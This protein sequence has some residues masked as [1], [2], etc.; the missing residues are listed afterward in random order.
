MARP[1]KAAWPCALVVTVVVPASVPPVETLTV[2]AT[3]ACATGLLLASRSC[4][5]GCV[6]SS[7]PL[8]AVVEGAVVS[9]SCV[10]VPAPMVMV[11]ELTPVRPGALKASVRPPEL[12]LMAR[13]VKL[14]TPL[15]LLCWVSVPPSVPPP[16]AMAAVTGTPA[17]A[18][19][20]PARSC[21]CT[22][23]CGARSA[24][25]CAEAPGAVARPSLLAG[26][27]PRAMVTVVSG[28]R[29]PALATRA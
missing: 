9:A 10:A 20:L 5:T 29:A 26:P 16:V 25:L 4:T 12:P 6:A 17:C 19:A 27:A 28:A 8:C 13:S 15:A 3:P 23:G 18:T 7:E 21:T 11:P 14:A 1:L 2:T 22:A 24:P